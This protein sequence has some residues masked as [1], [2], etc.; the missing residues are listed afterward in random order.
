MGKTTPTSVLD[1]DTKQSDGEASVM[2]ALWG[3]AEYR[4]IASAPTYI[5]AW[6]GST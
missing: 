2:L 3:N 4:F 6:R 5:L 1:H